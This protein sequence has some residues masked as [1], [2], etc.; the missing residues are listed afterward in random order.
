MSLGREG[1]V[2]SLVFWVPRC[3]AL[4]TS[5]VEESFVLDSSLAIGT[6]V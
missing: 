1:V 3:F 6:F 5:L 4:L 2:L